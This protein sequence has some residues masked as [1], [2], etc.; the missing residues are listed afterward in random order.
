MGQFITINFKKMEDYDLNNNESIVL[1][2]IDSLCK[3]GT[4]EYCFASNKTISETTKISER[5]LYRILSKLETKGL[6]T[7][8][9]KSIGKQGK[10]RRIL[11]N[12]PSANLADIYR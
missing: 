11:S 7:R 2:Y 4:K 10:E 12:L 9:T 5:T 1:E 8:K 3:N 6:I